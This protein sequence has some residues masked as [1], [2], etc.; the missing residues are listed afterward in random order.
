MAGRPPKNRK[1]D[2]NL[3]ERL[4]IAVTPEIK[5]WAAELAG[6]YGPEFGGTADFWRYMILQ[7]GKALEEQQ[8]FVYTEPKKADADEP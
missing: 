7:M 5:A 3:T 6:K 2:T 4:S 1:F 8:P